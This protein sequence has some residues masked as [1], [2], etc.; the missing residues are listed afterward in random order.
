[1]IN[2]I[3]TII[4]MMRRSDYTQ[5]T[6]ALMALSEEVRYQELELEHFG[7]E[8]CGTGIYAPIVRTVKAPNKKRGSDG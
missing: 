5:A 3:D 2:E 4:A 8:A 6:E 1:M 7:C